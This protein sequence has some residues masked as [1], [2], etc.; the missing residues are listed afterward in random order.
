MILNKLVFGDS[1]S[2]PGCENTLKQN[3]LQK[4][5]WCRLCRKKYRPTA[6]RGSW[7]YGM[8]LSPKQLF[9]ILWCW[10]NKKSPD[11]TR[12]LAQTSYTTVQRWYER[13]RQ[14]IPPDSLEQ[15][16]VHIQVDESYFGKRKSVQSQ[17]I[18]TGAIEP[19]TRKVALKI[20]G[21]YL[22]GRSRN[23]LERFIQDTTEQG[24]L[25]ITDKWYG[26]N[27][28]HLL[29]YDHESWNHSIGQFSATN[30]IE[31]LWSSI[32]RYLRKLYGC[33]PTKNLESILTE[34]VARQNRPSLFVSPENYLQATLVPF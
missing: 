23:V 16:S 27:E 19:H 2:C 21:D 20:T 28:L 18:V 14:Y 9:V 34:W 32:K 1:V 5:L 15:L 22:S 3:Y 6:Y 26:Y 24:T 31:G 8:K 13:F 4:Y 11:T 33:I 25:V 30:Q 10:Q 12:I 7:L 17:M 29:G